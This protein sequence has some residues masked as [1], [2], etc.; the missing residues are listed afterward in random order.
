MLPWLVYS[1][2]NLFRNKRRSLYIFLIIGFGFAA[3]NTFA[4]FKKYIYSTLSESYIYTA[5]NGHITIH[6]DETALE[7][8]LDNANKHYISKDD[9]SK[10]SK[11]AD[12]YDDVTL[13]YPTLYLT[14]LISDGESS[15]I[16]IGVAAVPSEFYY[17]QEQAKGM[18]SKLQYF[19][20][21]KLDDN[22][23]HGIGVSRKLA[24]KLGIGIGSSILLMAPSINGQLNTL[25]VNVVQFTD[26]TQELLDDKLIIMPLELA[27]SLLMTDGASR[28]H[29]LLNNGTDIDKFKS[30]I[31]DLAININDELQVSTWRELSPF[32]VKVEK[33][34][35][36]IFFFMFLIVSTVVIMSVVNTVSMSIYERTSEI[37]T[38]RTLGAARRLIVKVFSIEGAFL[39]VFGCFFG[40][41]LWLI[42]FGIISFVEPNW[43]PPQITRNI[44]LEIHADFL[45]I[46]Q[47]ACII[48]FLTIMSGIIP[49][50][51]IATYN[52]VK[53][54]GHV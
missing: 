51:R 20:G 35:H 50:Y 7:N 3:I 25:E 18:L 29:F 10:L 14:G 53:G 12:N 19:D 38:M 9:I 41:F 33:M 1:Y 27:R 34:F 49:A 22:L 21:N 31:T 15:T 24:K 44:P 48:I 54:L 32:Y 8:S 40:L 30:L 4:G 6:L 45:F 52:I 46:F 2:R 5:A 47:S 36:V 16:F 17:V 42:V 43:V 39:G 26:T 11:I 37:A 23:A 28:L 13:I